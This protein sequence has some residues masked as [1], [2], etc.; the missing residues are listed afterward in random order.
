VD[1]ARWDD[2]LAQAMPIVESF[3]LAEP[4]GDVIPHSARTENPIRAP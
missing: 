3:V 2:L 1:P 4:V